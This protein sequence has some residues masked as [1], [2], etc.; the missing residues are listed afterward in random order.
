MKTSPYLYEVFLTS[1]AIPKDI[2]L[3]RNYAAA[4]QIQTTHL[5]ATDFKRTPWK[6]GLGWTDQ[7]AIFPPGSDLRRG[8]FDWRLST[9]RVAQSADFS[10][11]AEHDRVLVVL[12][13]AGVTLSH[14]YDESSEPEIVEIPL[15][16][17]YEFPGDVP[18]GCKLKDGAIQDFSVFVRKGVVSTRVETVLIEADPPMIWEPQGTTCF[19]FA[20]Q[21]SIEVSG[22]VAHSQPALLNPGEILRIDRAQNS[23]P[24]AITL[25]TADSAPSTG[26]RALLV[27]IEH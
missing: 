13:G 3:Q 15:W 7:I 21:G 20:V 23:A 8:D 9:A 24:V 17:P 5:R 6:N 16:E 10:P 19:V 2:E 12:E 1:P 11:F 26:A 22:L 14:K 18:T 4:M 27:Q 25:K